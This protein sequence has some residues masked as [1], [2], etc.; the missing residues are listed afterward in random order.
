M[1]GIL[2]A[3]LIGLTITTAN[4][5]VEG[6]QSANDLLPYCRLTQEQAASNARNAQNLGLCMGV[7]EGVSKT[8][9]LLK[10]AQTA[11]VAQLDPLLCMSIPEGVTRQELVDVV[12]KYAEAFPELTERPFA[13]LVMSALRVAWPCRK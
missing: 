9:M 12:V 1:K 8:F 3:A 4:A 7:V 5:A 11:G 6:L 10:E 13:V 2:L